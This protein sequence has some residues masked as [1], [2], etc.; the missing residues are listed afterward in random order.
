LRLPQHLLRLFSLSLKISFLAA[1]PKFFATR[2]L[3]FAAQTFRFTCA[4]VLVFRWIFSCKGTYAD[5][6][7]GSSECMR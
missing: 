3:L 4:G 2:V 5:A 6:S 1:Q 7:G